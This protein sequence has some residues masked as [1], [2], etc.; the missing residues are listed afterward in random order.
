MS[1][2]YNNKILPIA[3]VI[4]VLLVVGYFMLTQPDQRTEMQKM[5]DAIEA[6]PDGVDK[7][8]RQLE[9]RTPGEKL[10]DVAKDTKEDIKKA[11]NH[12]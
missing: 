3:L 12:Q 11:T 9:E 7:A 2:T 5:G 8:A 10:N 1:Q 4:I 6:L